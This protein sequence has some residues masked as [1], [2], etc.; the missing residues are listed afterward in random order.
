MNIKKGLQSFLTDKMFTISTIFKVYIPLVMLRTRGVET[1]DII[2]GNF[3][4]FHY[5]SHGSFESLTYYRSKRP[6]IV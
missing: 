3:S 6:R 5:I 4:C 1:K 2:S